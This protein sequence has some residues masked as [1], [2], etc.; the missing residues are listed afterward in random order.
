M[1]VREIVIASTSAARR[2]MFA[3][4]GVLARAEAPGVDERAVVAPDPIA[5]AA[6][7]ARRKAEA[8][9]QRWPDAWVI[10]GDQV[11]WVGEHRLDKP[12][13]PEDHLAQLRRLRGREHALHSAWCLL[14][15]DGA[16][17]GGATARLVMRGDV[18]DAELA[19]YVASG[20]GSGCAGGYALEGRGGALFE[21]VD[22]D[23]FTILGIPLL[24]VLG[25]LRARGWRPGVHP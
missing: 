5:L 12:R 4:A 2:Q 14:G 10:G 17:E 15:P 8:V 16:S 25:A 13:D 6:A 7:L 18:D 3:A 11:G 9:A 20:E 24:D 21:R 22:G 19:A 23:F 1:A